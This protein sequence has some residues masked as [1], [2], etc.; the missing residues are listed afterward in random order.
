MKTGRYRN[1][2][3]LLDDFSLMAGSPSRKAVSLT[4][5]FYL[6]IFPLPG[7]STL[8]CL[9]AIVF[10]R[11]NPFLVQGMNILFTPFQMI[12]VYPFLKTGRLL[13]FNEKNVMP[14]ISLT[15][16]INA[17]N[18]EAFLYLFET[19]MAGVFIWGIIS[20]ATG[21]FLY[22]ILLKKLSSGSGI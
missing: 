12:L 16:W 8:L 9:L 7:S 10:F 21:F 11:L 13:F 17:E 3:R 5:G 4:F 20:G 22:R 6:G 2:Y 15:Q 18:Y 19:V 1:A 14:G